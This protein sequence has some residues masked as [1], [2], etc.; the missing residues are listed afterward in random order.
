MLPVWIGPALNLQDQQVCWAVI[1]SHVNQNIR[2]DNEVHRDIS[3]YGNRSAAGIREWLR[4]LYQYAQLLVIEQ[5][6]VVF[7]INYDRVFIGYDSVLSKRTFQIKREPM[8]KRL[9]MGYSEKTG[10]MF[11]PRQVTAKQR[12]AVDAVV[13]TFHGIS[14]QT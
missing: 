9:L 13:K 4:F 3:L 5:M 6:L 1:P 12:L 2:S 11:K 14:Q 8:G 7:A 10:W